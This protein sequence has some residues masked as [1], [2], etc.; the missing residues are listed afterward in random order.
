MTT[1]IGILG[2]AHG[3]VG[4]YCK[5]WL[6]NP[7]IGIRVVAGWD[8][9]A[10]RLA[11]STTEFGAT[12]YSNV[13]ELLARADISAVVIGVETVYH[14][15]IVEKAAAAGKMI[16]LQKPLALTLAQGERIAEAVR[17]SGV[18][19]TMAWQMRTDP[20][21]LKIKEVVQSGILGKIFMVRRRH[22]LSVQLWD[23]KSMWHFTAALNR[24]IWADDAAHPIDFIHWL[25]GVPETVSAEVSSLYN[26]VDAPMDNG[27]AV[28]R[29]ADGTLAEVNCSFTCLAAENT[30]EIIGEKGTLIQSY[31]DGPAAAAPRPANAPG[32]K[33]YLGANKDWTYS[34]IPSPNSQAAR[35]IGL[36]RPLADFFAGQ[37]GPIATADEAVTS[38]RMV[39][40]TYVSTRE[41][42]RVRIDDPAIALV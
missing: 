23:V 19:F 13:D 28:Y 20:Q 15:D 37:R 4:A 18:P 22:A 41:G 27:I 39:L 42:R 1:N 32:L 9:D 36:T 40:A 38:L 33:W 8:H 21:N 5:H 2:F 11:K 16:A 26:P 17:R 24:D 29:Y 30:T 31:G 10:N 34:E 35:L 14:A 12:A 25:M 6:Q 3:H 7:D